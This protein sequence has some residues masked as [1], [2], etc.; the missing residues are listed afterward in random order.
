MRAWVSPL[1]LG[2]IFEFRARIVTTNRGVFS[3]HVTVSCLK[4]QWKRVHFFIYARS[5]HL[6]V[7]FR[8]W[9]VYR[10]FRY[11]TVCVF[12]YI[13]TK[14][15]LIVTINFCVNFY[16]ECGKNKISLLMVLF[17]GLLLVWKVFFSS[18]F[19]RIYYFCWLICGVLHI[20]WYLLFVIYCWQL[21]K[22]F[23]R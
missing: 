17:A 8:T 7:N 16:Q 9:N 14:Q 1:L 4:V 20:S 10:L 12:A 2:I 23:G 19:R 22:R 6:F 5:N 21:I 3:F 13:W 15:W 18:F 11:K